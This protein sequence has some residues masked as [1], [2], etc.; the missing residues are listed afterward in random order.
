MTEELCLQIPIQRRK[1]NTPR[2]EEKHQGQAR[3]VRFKEVGVSSSPGGGSPPLH[4][5]PHGDHSPRS[6]VSGV[7]T[8]GD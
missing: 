5:V 8:G 7:T 2:P 4:T 3:D 6:S 1:K